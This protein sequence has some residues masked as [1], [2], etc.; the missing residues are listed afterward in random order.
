M[1]SLINRCSYIA[2]LGCLNYLDSILALT[3]LPKLLF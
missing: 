2:K 1:A 3:R